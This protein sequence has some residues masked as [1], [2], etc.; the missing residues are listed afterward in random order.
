[1]DRTLDIHMANKVIK[2]KGRR[3]LSPRTKGAYRAVVC[4]QVW[5][6][7]RLSEAGYQ[8]EPWCK[9]CQEIGQQAEDTLFHR[10]WLCQHPDV[11]AIR[12]ATVED[13]TVQRAV[14]DPDNP[15]FNRGVP[16]SVADRAIG[17]P[18]QAGI[19]KLG[20]CFLAKRG[21][22]FWPGAMAHARQGIL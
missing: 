3:A 5:T 11:V 12:K 10:W 7:K 2:A 22:D 8:T 13:S 19:P 18:S 1:M 6:R 21:K 15:L 17:P 4:N 9:L 14:N 16:W 20:M